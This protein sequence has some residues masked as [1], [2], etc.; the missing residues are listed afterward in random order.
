MDKEIFLKE[1]TR[2]QLITELKSR[3]SIISYKV[4]Q[5]NGATIENVSGK[6]SVSGE[7]YIFVIEP[8]K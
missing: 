1:A 3:D 8:N 4:L 5:G 2:D 7:A 6:I